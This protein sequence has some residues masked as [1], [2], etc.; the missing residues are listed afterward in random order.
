VRP[1]GGTHQ[2][3]RTLAQ[4]GGVISRST[5]SATAGAQRV[6]RHPRAAVWW[7]RTTC[8][9][10]SVLPSPRRRTAGLHRQD[11]SARCSSAPARPTSSA[12]TPVT[13]SPS[14]SGDACCAQAGRRTFSKG[15]L[16]NASYV[17]RA[18]CDITRQAQHSSCRWC[19][20][21]GSSACCARSARPVDR[22]APSYGVSRC[23][24][25]AQ[26]PA[27]PWARWPGWP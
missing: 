23:C 4:P 1:V 11:G 5:V 13:R 16:I 22:S 27:S 12:C 15:S 26:S 2:G 7:P 20:A 21:P 14:P 10:M 25:W 9:S 8:R 19:S 24:C 6:G 17:P 3:R 18:P